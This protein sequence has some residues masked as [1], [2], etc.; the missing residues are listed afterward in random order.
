MMRWTARS[1]H[2]LATPATIQ[3][4]QKRGRFVRRVLYRQGAG[5]ESDTELG[6]ELGPC[7]ASCHTVPVQIRVRSC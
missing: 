2:Q 5:A 7:L 4:H 1:R 6:T 3:T